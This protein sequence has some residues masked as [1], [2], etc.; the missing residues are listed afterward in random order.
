MAASALNINSLGVMNSSNRFET[1]TAAASATSRPRPSQGGRPVLPVPDRSTYCHL[2]SDGGLYSPSSTNTSPSPGAVFRGRAFAQLLQIHRELQNVEVRGKVGMFEAQI[3]GIR[4]QVRTTEL[5]RS[6]R[7][8]RR[9]AT[10]RDK[11]PSP[12]RRPGV[13]T[14]SLSPPVLQNG[15][16]PGEEEEEP[17]DGECRKWFR[18]EVE[19]KEERMDGGRSSINETAEE[20]LRVGDGRSE[21][22][23]ELTSCLE[24]GLR[25]SPRT[26]GTDRWTG[27]REDGREG[28][29]GT[30]TEKREGMREQYVDRESGEREAGEMPTGDERKDTEASPL[31][32]PTERGL[33]Q[34]IA[35]L[36]GEGSRESRPPPSDHTSKPSCSSPLTIPSVVVT[37]HGLDSM[38]PP[39]LPS[40]GR[41]S[42]QGLSCSPSPSSSPVPGLGSSPRSLRKLSSS[43]MS[44]AGFSSSWEESE[45]DVSSDTEKGD[46]F[47]NPDLLNSQQKAVSSI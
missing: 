9:Q 38:S 16:W 4:A 28:E 46:Q 15:R 29:E 35:D 10:G 47:L 2:I 20:S 34:E 27:G 12:F 13:D 18:T 22:G 36:T 43:S 8:P 37:D 7:P 5:Q 39:T 32:S 40:E 21:S 24:R 3:S 41:N 42:D 31:M 45:E 14:K 25:I 33:S 1:Q 11:S 23:T 26:K 30:R 6:P 19:G 17:R 44:S